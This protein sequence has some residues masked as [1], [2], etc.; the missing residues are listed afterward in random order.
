MND[1]YESLNDYYEIIKKY[2]LLSEDEE[3]ELFVQMHNGNNEAKNQLFLS[4]LRLV[5]HIAKSKFYNSSVGLDMLDIISEGNIGL[6]KS[7]ERYDSSKGAKFDTYAVFW[8]KQSIIRAINTKRNIIR[9]PDYIIEDNK[10]IYLYCQKYLEIYGSLPTKEELLSINVFTPKQIEL[11]FIYDL[12]NY[13]TFSADKILNNTED[14]TYDSEET[15]LSFLKDKDTCVEEDAIS[16]LEN[17]QF[18][19]DIEKILNKGKKEQ[20]LTDKH[21]NVFKDRYGLNDSKI[22]LNQVETGKKYNISKQ[23]V[24]IIEQRVIKYLKMPKN[25]KIL[26]CYL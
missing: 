1:N 24:S 12:S 26:K 8:I 21:I 7:I 19:E 23:R 22:A 5:V 15:Y 18:K 13:I 4:N 10:N 11:Y 16:S 20:I 3:K 2:P 6:W 14:N 17:S 9:L 25:K